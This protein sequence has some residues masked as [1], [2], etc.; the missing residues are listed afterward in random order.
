MASVGE[1]VPHQ[2]A[3]ALITFLL[4]AVLL[5]LVGRGWGV[6]A[7]KPKEASKGGQ[8]PLGTGPAGVED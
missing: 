1:H 8:V 6:V 2:S 3:T 7:S 4:L 5:V